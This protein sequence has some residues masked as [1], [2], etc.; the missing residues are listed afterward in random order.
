MS[1]PT[2]EELCKTLNNMTREEVAVV[3]K[4]EGVKIPEDLQEQATK[5]IREYGYDNVRYLN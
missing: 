5:R 3:A 2:F 1:K 4:V